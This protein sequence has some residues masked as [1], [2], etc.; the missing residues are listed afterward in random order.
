MTNISKFLLAAIAGAT[1]SL[2]TTQ[3]AFGDVQAHDATPVEVAN[4]TSL[5]TTTAMAC[6]PTCLAKCEARYQACVENGFPHCG[7]RHL[8]CMNVAS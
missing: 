5:E 1:L 7:A 4:P 6:G 2:L 3:S 8:E